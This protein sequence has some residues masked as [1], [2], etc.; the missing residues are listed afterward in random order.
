MQQIEEAFLLTKKRLANCNAS[1]AKSADAD[2]V[3]RQ[4]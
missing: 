1:K 3:N 4:D 2:T